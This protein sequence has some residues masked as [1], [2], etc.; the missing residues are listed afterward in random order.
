M[1]AD[2]TLGLGLGLG[3]NAAGRRAVCATAREMGPWRA[4]CIGVCVGLAARPMARPLEVELDVRPRC[5]SA[6]S[7]SV[8]QPASASSWGSLSEVASLAAPQQVKVAES[9]SAGFAVSA[10]AS[11]GEP[12]LSISVSAVCRRAGLADR[13]GAKGGG[14]DLGR[15]T[16]TSS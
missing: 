14:D 1:L 13:G 15:G 2:A 12:R 7:G 10:E 6:G 16:R 9:S 3:P 4:C 8:V 5:E 11:Q